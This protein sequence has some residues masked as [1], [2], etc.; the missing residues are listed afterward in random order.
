MLSTLCTRRTE[1]VA[2]DTGWDAPPTRRATAL[3]YAVL[4]LGISCRR[5]IALGLGVRRGHSRVLLCASRGVLQVRICGRAGQ[6]QL[7]S[8]INQ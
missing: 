1:Y 2:Y 4:T 3:T 7:I 8:G 6:L 5:I